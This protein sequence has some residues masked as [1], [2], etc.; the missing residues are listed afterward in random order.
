LYTAPSY[1]MMQMILNPGAR[2]QLGRH[3]AHVAEALDHHARVEDVQ[4]EIAAAPAW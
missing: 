4:A 2:H 3:A 1:S